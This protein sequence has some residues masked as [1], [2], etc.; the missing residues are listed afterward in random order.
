MEPVA[1]REE[2]C[3]IFALGPARTPGRT[4]IRDIRSLP[5]GCMMVCENGQFEIKR[6]YEPVVREHTED[7]KTTIEH[8]RHLLE[9]CVDDVVPL[10]PACML[11]GGIDSTAL[12]AL[13]SMH[14]GR[15]ESF[16]VDYRGNDEDF[17]ANAFRP[18]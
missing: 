3:E 12:T 9:M 6:Y 18:E 17:V 15:L 8:T 1:G 16:S 4:P 14:I 11:S 7:E 13:L 10:H 5:A 2:L